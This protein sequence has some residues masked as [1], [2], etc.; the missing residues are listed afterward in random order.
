M[1][2]FVQFVGLVCA[3]GLIEVAE[4]AEKN[5]VEAGAEAA[6]KVLLTEV[7]TAPGDW[8]GEVLRPPPKIES[9]FGSEPGTTFVGT[10]PVML[11]KD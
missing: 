9:P 3:S 2:R 1:A 11:T 5:V 6:V 8:T 10:S 4:A 7:L